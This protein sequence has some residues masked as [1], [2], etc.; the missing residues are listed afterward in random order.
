MYSETIENHKR[1]I[2]I[3]SHETE[4]KIKK[5]LQEQ[6]YKNNEALQKC[7]EFITQL[8]IVLCDSA[9][10]LESY[11]NEEEYGEIS[12]T[13]A[14]WAKRTLIDF[15][16]LEYGFLDMNETYTGNPDEAG[17]LI[18][19]DVKFNPGIILINL[20]IALPHKKHAGL[21]SSSMLSYLLDEAFKEQV[22]D[23][24]EKTK[25]ERAYIFIEH[26][27]NREIEELERRDCD[28]YDTKHLIDVI[29]KYFL[30]YGDGPDYVRLGEA[31]IPDDHSFTRAYV[32]E[33]EHLAD[34]MSQQNGFFDW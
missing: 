10:F 29:A 13:T 18:K 31:V 9:E 16:K 34:F 11:M 19:T 3:E 26:H 23:T 28:N 33:P 30:K 22:G 20:D 25:F 17:D 27:A 21:K 5:E 7:L 12:K 6:D 4:S 8:R 32:V 1:K 14:E 2:W 24:G 15:C